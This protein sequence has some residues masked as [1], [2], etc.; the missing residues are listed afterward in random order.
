ME[1]VINGRATRKKLDDISHRGYFMGY[2]DTTGVILYWKPDQTFIIHRSHNVWFDE[3]NYRLYTEDKHNPGSL[4]LWQD[5]EGHIHDSD[6]LNLI[7]F[8]HDITSTP[9]SDETIITY[10]I[11]LPPSGNKIGFNLLDDEDCTIPYIT[12]TIP[13]APAGHQLPSQAK[14]NVWIVAINVEEPITAQGVLDELNRHQNP[15]GKSKIK[16]SLCRRKRYQRT[17]LEEILSR[18]DQVRPLVSHL[19]F[20][21]LKKPPTPKN[22]GDALGGPQR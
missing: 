22:I 5:P 15:R 16:I 7:P 20:R 9:F 11:D 19:E 10:D 6:V 12:Y 8:E 2:A 18:F 4:L 13:N 1:K 3:Y 14:I 21:L 17:D